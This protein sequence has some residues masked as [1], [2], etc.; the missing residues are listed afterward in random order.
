VALRRRDVF[1]ARRIDA[2]AFRAKP[3]ID[4]VASYGAFLLIQRN[5]ATGE[6]LY[7]VLA[8]RVATAMGR[9]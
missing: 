9:P 2:S 8:S 6:R 7:D 1:V 3:W 5:T 4:P